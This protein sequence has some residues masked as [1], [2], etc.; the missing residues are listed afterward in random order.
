MR[1]VCPPIHAPFSCSFVFDPCFVFL[2][3]CFPFFFA[4]QSVISLPGF[5]FC[6]FSDFP[7]AFFANRIAAGAYTRKGDSSPSTL[8]IVYRALGCC[9]SSSSSMYNQ[10]VSV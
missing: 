2:F 9:C 7:M 6:F 10:K 5:V 8:A 1:L 4:C 3:S